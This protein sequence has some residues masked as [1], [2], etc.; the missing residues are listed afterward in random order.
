MFTNGLHRNPGPQK[1]NRTFRKRMNVAQAKQILINFL[2]KEKKWYKD[3]VN[4]RLL[5]GYETNQINQAF[6]KI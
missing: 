6:L 2:S 3:Q 1:F 4:F 5:L